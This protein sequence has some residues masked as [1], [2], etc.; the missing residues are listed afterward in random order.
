MTLKTRR[1]LFYILTVL[2]VIAAAGTVFYSTGYRVDFKNQTIVETGGVYIKSNPRDINITLNGKTIESDTGILKTGTL[3]DNL[4]PGNYVITLNSH[5]FHGW[6]KNV[7]VTP[8][9]VSIFDFVIL[10]PEGGATKISDPT[11][12]LHIQGDKFILQ[13][14]EVIKLK[15]KIISGDVIIHFTDGGNIITYSRDNKS[16]YLLNISDI[17]SQINLNILFNTLKNTQLGLPG[18]V[19]IIKIEPYPFDDDSFVVMT[20]RALYTMSVDSLEINQVNPSATDFVIDG[21]EVF[22]IDGESLSNLSLVFLTQSPVFSL[23][24]LGIKNPN[25]IGIN[26]S[27]NYLAILANNKELTLLEIN[28]GVVTMISKNADSFVF[29]PNGNVIVFVDNGNTIR[30][31][32]LDN[33]EENPLVTLTTLPGTL[34][35]SIVWHGNN[36]HVFVKDTAGILRFIEIDDNLPVNEFVVG[37]GIIDFTYDE[38]SKSLYFTNSSGIWQL[39]I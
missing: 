18:T 26:Q 32:R 8:G 17:D 7:I 15:G 1:L 24:K 13:S 37:R 27:G 4:T 16:Y 19:P 14:N 3:I 2:F 30:A 10:V 34:V 33:D 31:Y 36:N 38:D 6:Q 29:S 9:A 11:D 22:W 39:E 21:N 20:E 12:E 35:D 28:S 23:E 5:N 25:E